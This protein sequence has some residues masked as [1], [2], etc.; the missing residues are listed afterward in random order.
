MLQQGF[1]G[2]AVTGVEADP[3]ARLDAEGDA[4]QHDL[5]SQLGAYPGQQGDCFVTAPSSR[6]HQTE[7]VTTQPS[8]SIVRSK[9]LGEP[10]PDDPQQLVARLVTQG[11]VDL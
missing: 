8:H 1:E 9:G 6:Q 4:V 2:I 5:L 3:E 7:L 11:V 10:L